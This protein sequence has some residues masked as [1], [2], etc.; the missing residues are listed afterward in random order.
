MSKTTRRTFLKTTA[1]IGAG[2]FVATGT[3]QALSNSPN[4]RPKVLIVG[5]GGKGN[6]DSSNAAK[7]G[8]VIAICDV[9]RNRLKSKGESKGFQ[10]AETVHGLSRNVRQ[11]RQRSRRS[12]HQHAGP[13]ARAGDAARPCG[14]ASAATPRSP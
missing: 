1:A 10:D 7:F 5:V 3:R 9:D 14:W 11:V 6:S 13:H 4:A 12:H 8:D 2:Y